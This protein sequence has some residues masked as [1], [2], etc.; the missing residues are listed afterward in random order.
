[1]KAPNIDCDNNQLNQLIQNPHGPIR[2]TH[3]GRNEER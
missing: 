2:Q 1:M 3:Y